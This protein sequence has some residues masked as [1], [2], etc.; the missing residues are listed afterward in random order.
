MYQNVV[1][2]SGQEP[3]DTEETLAPGQIAVNA[4]VTVEFALK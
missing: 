2:N 3:A 1:Q 4:N